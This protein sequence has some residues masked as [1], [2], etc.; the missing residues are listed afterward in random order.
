[1]DRKPEHKFRFILRNH[2][3][4][5]VTWKRLLVLFTIAATFMLIFG[6]ILYCSI[7]ARW[8]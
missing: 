8:H 1:M 3:G 5:K 2:D 7:T 6:I 4:S